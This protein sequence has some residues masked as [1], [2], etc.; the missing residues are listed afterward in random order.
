M[1]ATMTVAA[2]AFLVVT[3]SAAVAAAQDEPAKRAPWT[4]QVL[5]GT[6]A[7]GRYDFNVVSGE[8]G[9]F[10]DAWAYADPKA[11]AKPRPGRPDVRAHAE[12]DPRGLLGKYKRWKSKGKNSALYWMAFNYEGEIK[13][14]FENEDGAKSKVTSL[15]KADAVAPLEADEPFLAWLVLRDR[16]E[17]EVPCVTTASTT[18]GKARVAKGAAT[19][20][21]ETWTVS[22]D[23]GA[24]TV[25]V[26]ADGEP[27]EFATAERKWVR[28]AVPK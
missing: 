18:V 21:G 28:A 11:M 23:C 17:R 1:R 4:F 2:A 26:G 13:L 3:A 8:G 22:G 19:A 27:V 14:R 15:G 7:V 6:K 24:F 10:A 25:V 5:K 12:L 9:V 16:A 20:V